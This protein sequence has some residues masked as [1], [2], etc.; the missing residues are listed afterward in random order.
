[1]WRATLSSLLAHKLRLALTT[2]AIVLGVAFVA[3]TL[4]Y[5]DT[6]RS[7]FDL[8][9]GQI[10]GS[11]DLSVRGLS[12]LG[13]ADGGDPFADQ[14]PEVPPAVADTIAEVEGVAAVERNV[15]GIA[16]I[17]GDDGQPLTTGNG[18][19]ALGFNAPLVEELAPSE[20]RRGR[21]PTADDE[22]TIDAGTA[23]DQGIAVGDAVAI[24]A[25]GPVTEYEIVG[26]FGFSGGVDNLAGAP[27]SLFSPDHAFD[28]FSVDDGY[29]SVDVLAVDGAR[30]DDLQDRIGAAVGAD[31]E[32]ITSD[33]LAAEQQAA[34]DVILGFLNTGL[35]VFAGVSL[36]VG[37][38][39]I[40]NT[41][42]IIVAQRSRELAL[43][44]AVGA[45]RLQ[46]MGSMLAEA[47]VVGVLASGV[48]LGLGA[49]VA[50]G[51]RAL[52]TAFG[53]DIP[54][55]ELVFA[56]RTG[57]VAGT[58]GI[59]VTVLSALVPAVKALRVPPVAAMQ[60]VAVGDP[61][62]SG[63]VRTTVGLLLAVVGLA[64]LGLG[65]FREAGFPVVIGGAMA[66]LL[67]AALLARFVTRPL[68]RVIGWPVDQLGIRG[69]LAREN[70]IRNPQRTASTAAA[71]MIGLGLVTFALIFGASLRES[72]TRTIDE[73]FVSDLQVRPSDFSTFPTD[74]EDDVAAL[75]EI[76]ATTDMRFAQIG[77]DG[78]AGGAA[79]IEPDELDAAWRLEATDGSLDDFDRGGMLV[80]D[81]AAERLGIGAGDAQPVIF[82][83]TG[84]QDLPVRAV[85]D[86]SGLDFDYLI[87]EDTLLANGADEGIFTLY[88]TVADGV[89]VEAA[90]SAVEGVT[91]DY[92]SLQ[93]QD[94]EQFKEEIAG[95]VDQ[96]LG[97]MTALLGL[98]ILIALFGIGNTLS[99]SVFERTR[100]LGLLRAVGATRRQVRS[101][102]RWESVLIAVLGAVF[103]IVVGTVFGW[104]TVLALADQ[105]L[106]TFAFPT[107]QVAIAV[108]A[109][110]V[111]GTV[112]AW[113][114]ARRASRV[115]ILRAVATT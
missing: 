101:I 103:G 73:Q 24:A 75:P 80:T 68:L 35:L 49:L 33:Q 94:S 85:V 28:L 21:Y 74:V 63:R 5:T 62:G 99:L 77:I 100:E 72:T 78:R 16:Q 48:G 37:A 69:T 56:A 67:G 71:L 98:S 42:A 91:D 115:D 50:I 3:G 114:P 93:V 52:L 90:R 10:S 4:I 13:D 30:L 6:V 112:A 88:L 55:T 11:I 32:V 84:E 95:Q 53:I 38:F 29:A 81:D 39:L 107:G 70:S 31:Y 25:N 105:G 47:L 65:L 15:E 82:P 26:I 2:L 17:V 66:L 34:A 83:E 8:V 41:F 60:A 46:V 79:G 44:R 9:F 40:N 54:S 19:P 61:S 102:V 7:S 45:S 23:A 1:M 59:V 36:L 104:M 22:V 87:D 96:L 86:G 57:L 76:A 51:L 14:R 18:P 12:Q 58:L 27:V 109:A 20:L 43:L 89:S 111:A 97:L 64:L 92:P 110:A 108:I 113:L 106:S